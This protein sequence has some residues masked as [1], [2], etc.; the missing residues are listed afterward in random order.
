MNKSTYIIG[1]T[2]LI[3][4]LAM[5]SGT[6]TSVV[7][8]N[9][10]EK[11]ENDYGDIE[12]YQDISL[13]TKNYEVEDFWGKFKFGKSSSSPTEAQ[14]YNVS[15][16]AH[17]KVTVELSF[18]CKDGGLDESGCSSQK[19]F[20]INEDVLN[21]NDMKLDS[22]GLALPDGEYR[23]PFDAATNYNANNDDA[24][25]SLDVFRDGVYYQSPAVTGETEKSKNFFG[26]LVSFFKD[27]FSPDV[28]TYSEG[29]GSPEQ[30]NRYIA[31]ITFGAQQDYRMKRSSAIHTA[32]TN[33]ANVTKKVSLL[34]Y[35][36]QIVETTDGCSGLFFSYDPD[37]LTCKSRNFFGLS[38]FMPF[39]NDIEDVK[40]KSDSVVED[41][42]TTLLT[43]AG[44]LDNKNYV[45]DYTQNVDGKKTVLQNIFKPVT[46][47][48]GSMFRFFFGNNSQNLTEMVSAEF[49]FDNPMPLTFIET[50]GNIVKKFRQFYLMAI[51]SIYGTEVESCRVKDTQGFFGWRSSYQTFTKGVPT[52]TKF[53]M[54][55]GGFFDFFSS[56]PDYSELNYK[57]EKHRSWGDWG[58]HDVVSVTTD[59]WLDWCKRNQGRQQKGLFGRIFASFSTSISYLLNGPTRNTTYDSQLDGLLK[60]ENYSVDEY[61]E[62][63][64]K[65]LIL[66]LK[67]TSSDTLTPDTQGTT[68]KFQI[69]KTTKG[70]S[71]DM[72]GR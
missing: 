61:R 28:A 46:F 8:S 70:S 15:T 67:S 54:E 68:T 62:K 63:V 69:M 64:H 11:I 42:E 35:N 41:T 53:D 59:D 29:D 32:E 25:Y 4:S 16:H 48:A 39:V 38:N 14:M 71:S 44:K 45:H 5:A 12:M 49:T 65:G 60:D 13:E 47:M 72:G 7:V 37:S 23:I 31:N 30:R 26:Y 57:E 20:L 9:P 50:D 2:L 34:D 36:S 6:Q 19:P 40:V 56:T 22:E 24:F 51:E 43:L 52:T 27:Y 55:A 3:S 10:S 58:T 33:T 1:A 17:V 21:N 66:H 18:A